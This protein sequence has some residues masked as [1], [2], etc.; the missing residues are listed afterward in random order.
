M[1]KQA[2]YKGKRNFIGGRD[3]QYMRRR[4]TVYKGGQTLYNGGQTAYDKRSHLTC[5]CFSTTFIVYYLVLLD[6]FSND[7]CKVHDYGHA[8]DEHGQY[9]KYFDENVRYIYTQD[10]DVQICIIT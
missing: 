6:Y 5:M 9:E 1:G 4:Q 2:V 10:Y 8:Y 3:R 7:L